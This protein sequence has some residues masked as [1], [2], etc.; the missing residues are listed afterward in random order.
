MTSPELSL[1]PWPA[2]LHHESDAAPFILTPQA[3][4]VVAGERARPLAQTLARHLETLTGSVPAIRE[5]PADGVS[6][7]LRLQ[8][9]G[10]VPTSAAAPATPEQREVTDATGRASESYRL[11]VSP[12][13]VAISSTAEAGLFYG[14]QTLL[15]LLPGAQTV[16]PIMIPALNISDSPRFAYRGL[17]LDI[18]RHFFGPEEIKRHIDNAASF[19]FNHLHLHLTDDQGWRIEIESWPELTGIG[20]RSAV[21]GP[22][23]GF[24]SKSDYRELVEYAAARQVMIVPEI[25]LPGHSNA[26]LASYPEL[27]ESGVAPALYEGIEVGFSSLNIRDELTYSF[28]TDVLG[29]IAEMTPGRYLHIGGDEALK[30]P[31]EDYLYFISRVG[32]IVA[33]TGKTMVGWHE[34]GKSPDALPGT[35]AQYWGLLG[36][37]EER[38]AAEESL[39]VVS[40]GGSVILSPADAVYLDMSYPDDSSIGLVWAGGPTSVRES[41]E[42]E[43][44]DAIDGLAEENILGVEAALWTE[45]IETYSQAEYMTYPRALSVA[46]IG[47]SPRRAEA[48]GSFE[49]FEPRLRAVVERLRARGV[50]VYPQAQHSQALDPLSGP[51]KA[52]G[53]A[54][55]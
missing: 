38:K 21:G 14:V 22:P 34:I 25:D 35:V 31:D 16:E 42:W 5:V 9:R 47:W 12:D 26:A 15:Q 36:K 53:N 46:E 55:V 1:I 8:A 39:S 4:L 23:G 19:K 13:G 24:L 52:Q 30:T 43:P 48:S 20:S 45:T 7:G 50:A 54:H 44:A 29:E 27:N 33:G 49:S 37:P 32:Q 11:T 17:M 28:I 3:V 18:S 51:K 6:L 41:Y 40:L 10:A 2:E